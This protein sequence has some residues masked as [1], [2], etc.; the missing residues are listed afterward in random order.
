MNQLLPITSTGEKSDQSS[1]TSTSSLYS[2]TSQASENSLSVNI[3]A[4]PVIC[5]KRKTSS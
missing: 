1:M 5:T 4:N 2:P 3:S